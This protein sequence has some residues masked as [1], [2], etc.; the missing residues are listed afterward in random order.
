MAP[1]L[2]SPTS[3]PVPK[4]PPILTELPRRSERARPARR[5]LPAVGAVSTGLAVAAAQRP[6]RPRMP[7]PVQT[8]AATRRRKP[9]VTP[10]ARCQARARGVTERIEKKAASEPAPRP[11]SDRCVNRSASLPRSLIHGRWPSR[12]LSARGPDRAVPRGWHAFRIH[13]P[14]PKLGPRRLPNGKVPHS[15]FGGLTLW[16]RQGRV[17]LCRTGRRSRSAA[18]DEVLFPVPG[19]LQ[20]VPGFET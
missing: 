15:S 20:P 17:R 8:A 11:L 16:C 3:G 9:R 10:G 6:S 14:S 4:A 2:A 19:F 18:I 1:V 13:Q 5:L 12:L 7:E